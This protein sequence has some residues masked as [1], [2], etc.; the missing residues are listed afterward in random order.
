M[1]VEDI[2]RTKL[3][4]ISNEQHAPREHLLS[5]RSL[6]TLK[7]SLIS[8][9]V[10]ATKPYVVEKLKRYLARD[11]VIEPFLKARCTA[12]AILYGNHI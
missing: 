2:L 7:L 8:F 9:K 6:E 12:L 4:R 1:G 3:Q 10:A 11:Y 5:L